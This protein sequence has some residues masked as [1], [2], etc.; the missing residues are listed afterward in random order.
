M[1]KENLF[2]NPFDLLDTFEAKVYSRLLSIADSYKQVADNSNDDIDQIIFEFAE[3]N[4]SSW[5]GHHEKRIWK[6]V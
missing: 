6:Y 3:N 1:Q 4:A 2:T 5:A